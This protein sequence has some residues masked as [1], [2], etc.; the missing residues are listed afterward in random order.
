MSAIAGSKAASEAGGSV[1]PLLL[2]ICA[3]VYPDRSLYESGC[4]EM[5]T[6]F[7]MRLREGHD[8]VRV[9]LELI[10]CTSASGAVIFARTTR[11]DAERRLCELR[12]DMELESFRG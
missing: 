2:G 4:E 9:I 1:D 6:L 8:D 12:R 7:D 11:L 5:D 10:A 3:G